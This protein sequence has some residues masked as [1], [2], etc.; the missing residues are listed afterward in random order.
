[1]VGGSRVPLAFTAYCV[2]VR[3]GIQYRS[4][5]NNGLLRVRG[6]FFSHEAR[7]SGMPS[8][9]WCDDTAIT[10]HYDWRSCCHLHRIIQILC[11]LESESRYLSP[12][13]DF[14]RWTGYTASVLPGG[15]EVAFVMPICVLSSFCPWVVVKYCTIE[16]HLFPYWSWR[17][18]DLLVVNINTN[19]YIYLDRPRD[20]GHSK[21]ISWS[22]VFVIDSIFRPGCCSGGGYYLK[23]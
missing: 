14:D 9:V 3:L 5:Q 10:I 18:R 23:S 20:Q 12:F 19:I 22:H 21:I 11:S 4:S 17:L 2:N 16:K 15:S 13:W 7:F 6:K 8:V 1:M